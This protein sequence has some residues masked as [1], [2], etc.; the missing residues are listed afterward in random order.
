MNWLND[1]NISSEPWQVE[2]YRNLPT[3][4]LFQNLNERGIALDN[5]RFINFTEMVDSPEDFTE[6]LLEDT[7]FDLMEQDRIF[8]HIFELWRRLVP[9]KLCL[10]IFCDE[11]DHQIY[12]YD[13][14]D[15][16]SAESIQDAIANL[17]MILDENF[18]QGMKPSRIFESVSAGCANDLESFLYDFTTEQINNDNIV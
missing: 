9:E 14:G 12:L 3:Q 2:D 10:S 13:S 8:L 17:Q 6:I 15:P 16:S 11:L 1:P 18:D 4:T 5:A 7:S